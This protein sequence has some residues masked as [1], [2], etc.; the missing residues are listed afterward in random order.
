[1][2]RDAD[3]ASMRVA[4]GQL[5]T[6]V[7]DLAGNRRLVEEAAAKAASERADMVAL[8]EMTL[9]G[10]PPMVEHPPRILPWMRR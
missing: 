7:G 6:T 2:G 9:T 5:N 8:P 10:Y 4:I 1:M 3:P